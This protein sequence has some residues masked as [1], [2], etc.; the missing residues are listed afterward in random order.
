MDRAFLNFLRW[1]DQGVSG[2]VSASVDFDQVQQGLAVLG[3]RAEAAFLGELAARRE[4]PEPQYTEVGTP[5]IQIIQDAEDRILPALRA[6]VPSEDHVRAV[7]NLH[8]HA[9]VGAWGARRGVASPYIGQTWMMSARRPALP[10]V[11]SEEDIAR[12]TTEPVARELLAQAG[13]ESAELHVER[14]PWGWVARLSAD[15]RVIAQVSMEKTRKGALQSLLSSHGLN[16][17]VWMQRIPP[18]EDLRG[19]VELRGARA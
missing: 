10:H 19:L 1:V 8:G 12:A 15:R 14:D 3:G 16:R 18:I 17:W 4:S 13:L 5:I 2:V 9:L 11:F 6:M 7:L